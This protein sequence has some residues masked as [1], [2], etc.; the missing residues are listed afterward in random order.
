MLTPCKRCRPTHNHENAYLYFSRAA[1]LGLA[2]AIQPVL[3]NESAL[4]AALNKAEAAFINHVAGRRNCSGPN[5]NEVTN[6]RA[7]FS[8]SPGSK[9]KLT[10]TNIGQLYE[11]NKTTY[12]YSEEIVIELIQGEDSGI[13]GYVDADNFLQIT[14][15]LV[16]MKR[17]PTSGSTT[18]ETMVKFKQPC[19]PGTAPGT[20]T[21]KVRHLSQAARAYWLWARDR[22]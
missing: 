17:T 6:H 3:A 19:K 22:G 21:E 2:A 20:F 5:R 14:A 8:W 16:P 12:E 9:R 18:S 13:V 7:V 1:W 10:L 4:K 15:L 11:N